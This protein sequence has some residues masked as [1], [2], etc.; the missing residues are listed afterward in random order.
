[1]ALRSVEFARNHGVR[2]HV[3]STFSDAAGHVD[4]G[5]GRAVAGE[6]DHLGGHARHLRGEADDLRRARPARRRRARLP[7][8][9]RRG[10]NIDMI[11][12]NV[13]E[14]GL[15]DISFTLPKADLAVAEPILEAA[16]KEVGAAGFT[17]DSDIAKVSLIGAGMRSAPGRRRR[18][19][20]GAR[21]GRDQHRDH[22]DV[23]DPHLVRRARRRGRARR[24]R[25]STTSSSSS[26]RSAPM[27]KAR[28]RRRDR[29]GREGHAAAARRARLRRRARV[30][31]GAVGR[32]ADRVRRRGARRRGGDAR[33]ARAR[34][35][36]T[37]ACSRSARRRRASSCRT[38]CAAA[39][40]CVD[41]SSAYRLADGVP[42]VVPE[43]NGAR[44]L[45][46]DG[47]VANPNCCTIPLTCVLKPLEEAARLRRVRVAT[48]QSVS[49]AG[50]RVDGA[51][52][53]RAAG[54]ARPARG[55]GLRRRRVRRGGEAPRSRRGRSWSCPTCRSARPA[56]AYR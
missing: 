24:R 1:M 34:A 26:P 23:V 49:G 41:K 31:V 11:V 52:R 46:H 16:C 5:G 53:R 27:P 44:A 36:S 45:E 47:I 43:V 35:T 10:V 20:R 50:R 21:R 7:R 39:R 42:L 2:L 32:V 15:T 6:G 9:R 38:R 28:R 13:S 12:Q 55:L 19:V 30:R 17:Q 54:R 37:S 33:G 8:A 51:A 14:R 3:R 56:C 40:S 4:P 25:P 29:R 22:L 48:Y 18:H